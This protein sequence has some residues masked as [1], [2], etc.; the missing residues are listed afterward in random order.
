VQVY[1]AYILVILIWS[2]TPLAIQWSS[3]SVPFMTSVALRMSLALALALLAL[4]CLRRGALFARPGVWKVYLVASLG[5]FPNM[6]L[7]YWSAQ[8]VPSGLMAV[9]FALSPFVTGLLSMAILRESPFSRLRVMALFIALA[10]LVVIFWG[11]LQV[12][13]RSVFGIVGLLL[14]CVLFGVSSVTLKR[15]N[16]GTDAFRQTA[17]ALLFA[18]PGL[19]LTWWWVDGGYWPALV[20]GRTLWALLYLAVFGS[21]VGFTLFYYVLNRLSPS[22]VS[23]ITLIT[24]ILA[25]SIGALVA[26]EPLT[27]SLLLGA[28]LVMGALLLY[29][30]FKPWLRRF[31]AAAK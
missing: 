13:A 15:L 9:I 2:T 6:P 16:E 19:L 25:L 4:V 7:V 27:V 14:S 28:T 1:L 22:S 10:G 20:A 30:D 23:L 3:D 21:V 29:L 24:P 11:Q 18:L 8:F 5:I 26:R 12:D 31:F 17:G